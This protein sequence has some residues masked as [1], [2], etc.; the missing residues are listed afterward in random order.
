[1]KTPIARTVRHGERGVALALALFVMAALTVGATS[2][3]FIGSEDIKASRNYRG[4]AQAHFAAESGLTR[5]VQR[6]NQVGVIDFKNEIVD[7]WGNNWFGATAQTFPLD[8]YTYTLTAIE[9]AGNPSQL[10]WIR[11]TANGPENVRNIAVARVQQ[12][13]QPGTAPGAIYLANPS[14]TD[15]DFQG[16]AFLVDGKDYNTNGTL[17]AGGV[18]VPGIA[19]RSQAN[20]QEAI[21]SL[22]PSQLSGVQGLGYQA[23]PPVVPSVSTVSNGAN[24]QQLQALVDTLMANPLAN[25]YSNETI[26]NSLKSALDG[27]CG[28]GCCTPPANNPKISVFTATELQAK[29]N[30]NLSGCG[31]MIFNGDVDIQGTIDFQGLIIVRGKTTISTDSELGITGNANILGS[32]WTANLNLDVGGHSTV[33]YSTAALAFANTVMPTGAFPAPLNVLGLVNCTQVPAGTAGCPS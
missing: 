17:K 22:N 25:T 2:A 32:L 33:K 8:G 11:A 19:T 10:G 6:I 3:L 15:S 20:T 30:G 16:S 7:E 31:I 21:N 24:V 13:N 28:I 1:M 18:A 27:S 26:N 4:A 12:S 14:Q 23:G 29:F 9:D 5:A